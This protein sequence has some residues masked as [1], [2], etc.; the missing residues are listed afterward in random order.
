MTS[1]SQYLRGISQSSLF[2]R[3]SIH[4]PPSAITA[5]STT[6]ST[7]AT[8]SAFN[9]YMAAS[10]SQAPPAGMNENH[11]SIS[12][13]INNPS[14][15][16]TDGSAVIDQPKN[17]KYC[18]KLHPHIQPSFSITDHIHQGSYGNHGH[19]NPHDTKDCLMRKR[20]EQDPARPV[21]PTQR[22]RLQECSKLETR[23]MF[24]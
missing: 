21:H 12:A 22:V 18:C 19:N 24:D 13:P 3:I 4:H 10:D 2:Y 5:S 9:F 8:M 1:S 11:R 14:A 7:I 17:T 15:I 20:K 23:A 6:A 16:S